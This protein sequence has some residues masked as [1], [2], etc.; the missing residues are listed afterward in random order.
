MSWR[1]RTSSWPLKRMRALAM[2]NE[3]TSACFLREQQRAAFA[4]GREQRLRRG[5]RRLEL[6]PVV[7]KARLDRQRRAARPGARARTA[8]VVAVEVVRAQVDG[9]L[10]VAKERIGEAQPLL[11]ILEQHRA[12]VG[13]Q[14]RA[15]HE[16]LRAAGQRRL[17]RERALDGAVDI[18]GAGR[19]AL[20]VVVLVCPGG[21]CAPIAASNT[22][23]NTNAARDEARGCGLACMNPQEN[24]LRRRSLG[25]SRLRA[26]KLRAFSMR[27]W[28]INRWIATWRAHRSCNWSRSRQLRR[29]ESGVSQTHSRAAGIAFVWGPT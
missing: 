13:R 12:V 9:E 16:T 27:N 19:D 22:T 7:E 10:H 3:L 25:S 26:S 24:Q 14:R 23:P 20:G 29:I 4:F 6:Q 28:T 17:R 2:A 11:Q 5:A 21:P 1:P 15:G 8:G 18:G